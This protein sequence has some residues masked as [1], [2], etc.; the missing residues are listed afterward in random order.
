M[1]KRQK[2]LFMGLLVLIT[3][4]FGFSLCG[5][6]GMS[7][8]EFAGV[9]FHTYSAMGTLSHIIETKNY[10][11]MQDSVRAPHNRELK[12]YIE[13][14]NK[15]LERIIISH[16]CDHHWMGLELFQGKKIYALEGVIKVIREKCEEKKK[17]FGISK[18]VIPSHII[19]PGEETIDGV[20]F[21]FIQPPEK[22][23][24]NI[25]FIEMPDQKVII[26]HHLAFPGLHN[27]APY[28]PA[29]IAMLK[30]LKAK[31]YNLVMTGHGVPM[32]GAVYADKS[33]AYF[34]TVENIIKESPDV[35]TAKEKMMKAYP[36]YG[37][38]WLLDALL[39]K[40]Y[41]K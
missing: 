19:N 33:I 24:S 13:S 41:K 1:K 32:P 4:S 34:E 22:W 38:K 39:P 40:H 11:F 9:K 25:L 29:R 27:P 18:F 7:V 35:K 37:A 21:S 26:T 23:L 6:G 3:L 8:R 31:N 30:D 10:L 15:P 5:A 20:R 14:L 28:I 17:M 2:V 36:N 16:A 12:Q